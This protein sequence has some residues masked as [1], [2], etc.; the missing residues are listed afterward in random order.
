MVILGSPQVLHAH[1]EPLRAVFGENP[2][3]EI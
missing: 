2:K 3:R 1:S